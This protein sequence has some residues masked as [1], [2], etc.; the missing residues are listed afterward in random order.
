[1]SDDDHDYVSTACWHAQHGECSPE[2]EWCGATCRC[3]C[4][5]EHEPGSFGELLAESSF[6]GPENQARR[7]RTPKAVTEELNKKLWLRLT[8]GRDA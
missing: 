4:H 8:D 1:M 5:D 7:A 3:S 6:G 2:C